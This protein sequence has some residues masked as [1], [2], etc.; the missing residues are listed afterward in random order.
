MPQSC[1]SHCM[2]CNFLELK[3]RKLSTLYV[4]TCTSRFL[5]LKSLFQIGISIVPIYVSLET[6]FSPEFA[7]KLFPNHRHFFSNSRSENFWKQNT[8]KRNVF[9]FLW[10]VKR[11][12][13]FGTIGIYDFLC[14]IYLL[15][16][17]VISLFV[18]NHA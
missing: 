5:H 8:I 10:F 12:L 14:T 7:R 4:L 17:F 16:K 2:K 11:K 3:P 9:I 18:I 6:Y 15:T 1:I 13:H